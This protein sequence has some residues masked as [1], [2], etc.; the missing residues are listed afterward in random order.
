MYSFVQTKFYRIIYYIF[1][2]LFI[3]NKLVATRVL[4]FQIDPEELEDAR[5]FTRPEVVQ[6][7]TRQHP[8]GL[9]VPPEQAIAHQIIKT[10]VRTTANL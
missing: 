2:V 5:W 8:Q 1:I 4:V 10:W 9:F 7:L 3:E 6:M